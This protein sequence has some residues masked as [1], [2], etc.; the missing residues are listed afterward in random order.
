MKNK[1]IGRGYRRLHFMTKVMIGLGVLGWNPAY[2]KG[3]AGAGSTIEAT[4]PEICSIG[5][6]TSIQV[7]DG[8]NGS[9]SGTTWSNLGSS[10]SFQADAGVRAV[11]WSKLFDPATA[12]IAAENVSGPNMDSSN[13]AAVQMIS[14]Y[15]PAHC[16]YADTR[17]ALKSTKGGMRLA[18]LPANIIGNFRN[19]IDYRAVASWGRA[20][21][22]ATALAGDNANYVNTGQS[23]LGGSADNGNRFGSTAGGIAAGAWT[24]NGTSTTPRNAT[25]NLRIKPSEG[26]VVPA[27]GYLTGASGVRLTGANANDL[28]FLAGTYS[29]TLVVRI[30]KS[31]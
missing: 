2:A 14:M 23:T 12:R 29:D 11:T 27:A 13:N 24:P 7:G 21:S 25:V 15:F 10:Q 5:N 22:P 3:T 4:T 9:D 19:A 18:A 30:G 1:S 31:F 17:I 28:P 26:M 16:N 20:A 8:V 6:V